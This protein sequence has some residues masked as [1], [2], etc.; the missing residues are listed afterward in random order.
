M[1]EADV[2]ISEARNKLRVRQA[3]L[4]REAETTEKVARVMAVK[5][6]AEAKTALEKPRVELE[7]TRLQADMIHPAEAKRIAAEADA[8][9]IAAPI[10]EKGRAQAEVLRMLYAEINQAGDVGLQV[11]MAEKLPAL[12]GVTVEAMKDVNIVR[13]TVVDSG[14]GHGVANAATQRVNASIVALEQIA[15]AMGLDLDSFVKKIQRVGLPGT[16]VER[17]GQDGAKS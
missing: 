4:D 15:G 9:A 7:R 6:E 16:A 8:K 10:L 5:A 1:A 11:F 12:L 17:S 14:G 3:E 2:S 13:L